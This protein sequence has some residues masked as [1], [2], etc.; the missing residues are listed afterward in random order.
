MGKI[1]T[2]TGDDGTTGLLSGDRVK[3][4]NIRLKTY[5]ELDHLNSMV[6]SLVQLVD[7]KNTKVLIQIQNRIFDLGSLLA[8]DAE[9]RDKFKLKNIASEDITELESIIDEYTLKLPPLKNFILPGGSEAASRA[10][11]CRTQTRNV[12]RLMVE[13]NDDAGELPINSIEFINRLSDFFFSLA[14]MINF[15]ANKK[16]IE[17]SL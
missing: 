7:E 12:E 9:S 13:L 1:Y 8:C 14:R 16:E 15:E 3:K 17:W 10:H 5:G 11:L 4:S 2:K 6:G